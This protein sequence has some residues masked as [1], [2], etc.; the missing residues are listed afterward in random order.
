MIN[1]QHPARRTP[2]WKPKPSSTRSVAYPS[3]RRR[4]R[5]TTE[6]TRVHQRVPL[7]GFN[8]GLSNLP[9]QSVSPMK[10]LS[11]TNNLKCLCELA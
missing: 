5:Q 1:I 9:D 6:S 7:T 4:R 3:Y 10:N 11:T 2:A 8:N